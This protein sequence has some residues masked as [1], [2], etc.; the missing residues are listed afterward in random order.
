MDLRTALPT[1][2]EQRGYHHRASDLPRHWIV[3]PNSVRTQALGQPLLRGLFP[4]HVGFF[5]RASR[6]RVQRPSGVEQTIVQ[7]CVRGRG[8][9]ELL[10]NRF[11]VGAGDVMVVPR[12]EPHAYGSDPA[13]PWT[14]HWFHAA[15]DNLELLLGELGAS[16]SRPVIHLGNDAR[17]VAL[18]E[19]LRQLLEIDYSPP[20][21]FYAAQLLAHLVGRMIWLRRQNARE[22]QEAEQRVLQSVEHIKEHLDA[23]FELA[24]L[25]SLSKLS[26]SHY[27]ALFRRLTGFS[28]KNYAT[29]LR[30]HR[31]AQM[32]GTTN[33]SVKTVAAMLGY[34]DALYFSRLFRRINGTTP[35]AYR[36]SRSRRAGSVA[37]KG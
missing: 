7:Y 17:L 31:A 30:I 10:D 8:F 16:R 6:H 23:P 4:T 32:L 15:G 26:P 19:E 11:D 33:H 14:V 18:F 22:T 1:T 20:R 37:K 28:P 3:L 12:R 34:G 9:C 2:F 24:A 13:R 36:Q 35:S 25:A 29:R 5:P 27:S 21:L